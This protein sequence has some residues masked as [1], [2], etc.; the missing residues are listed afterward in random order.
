ML[1]NNCNKNETCY[2]KRKNKPFR[3]Q[4]SQNLMSCELMIFFFCPPLNLSKNDNKV[5]TGRW[6]LTQSL[7][8]LLKIEKKIILYKWKKSLGFWCGW[9]INESKIFRILQCFFHY[10]LELYCMCI[11]NKS[12]NSVLICFRLIVLMI[13]VMMLIYGEMVYLEEECIVFSVWK[14]CPPHQ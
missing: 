7:N 13:A 3:V 1:T 11:F 14:K 5:G 4:C 12:F 8:L 6:D 9:Y 10:C 2:A